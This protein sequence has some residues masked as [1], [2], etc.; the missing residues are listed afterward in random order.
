MPFHGANEF[1]EILCI[2]PKGLKAIVLEVMFQ[3]PFP[4]GGEIV[5]DADFAGVG[6]T[7]KF[8]CE[9]TTHKSGAAYNKETFLRHVDSFVFRHLFTREQTCSSREFLGGDLKWKTD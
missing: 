1:V 7:Q 9:I 3:V 8:I 5:E 6:R 2:T 4:T